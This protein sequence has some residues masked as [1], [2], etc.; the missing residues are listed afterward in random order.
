MKVNESQRKSFRPLALAGSIATSEYRLAF[1]I[2]F[3]QCLSYDL[4]L[5]S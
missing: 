4:N 3:W 1:H 2:R 5:Y